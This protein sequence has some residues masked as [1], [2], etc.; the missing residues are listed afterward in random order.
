MLR[1]SPVHFTDQHWSHRTIKV[2]PVPCTQFSS[3]KTLRN[4]N[5]KLSLSETNVIIL[6][7]KRNWNK[8]LQERALRYPPVQNNNFKYQM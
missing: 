6:R 4:N 2:K 7:Y 8:S 3:E 1:H 5:R